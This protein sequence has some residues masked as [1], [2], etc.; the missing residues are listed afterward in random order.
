[1]NDELTGQ[2]ARTGWQ[3]PE[4]AWDALWLETDSGVYQ[5]EGHQGLFQLD[6]PTEWVT[7]RWGHE[8]GPALARLRWQADSL[9][10]D[11]SVR[12][13]G[14]LDAV[15]LTALPV[16]G[17]AICVL[18]VV[19]QPLLPTTSLYALP[20]ARRQSAYDAPD[21]LEGIADEVSESATTWL[22]GEESPLMSFAHDALLNGLRLWL[23]GRLA[24]DESGWDR[25]FGLPLLVEAITLFA[26]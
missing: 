6:A 17:E 2:L 1:M 25:F 7:V 21:F 4:Y 3:I 24:D 12:I 23:S 11:G 9:G 14:S 22:A 20:E 13:G 26:V 16:T 8:A 5:A 19:G 18:Y 10:W 15:H